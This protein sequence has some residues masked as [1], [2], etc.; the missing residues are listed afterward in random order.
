MADF[1]DCVRA[2]VG[3]RG[4]DVTPATSVDDRGNGKER[5]RGS[6]QP[7]AGR[8]PVDGLKHSVAKSNAP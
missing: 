7:I 6:N 4:I 2:C 1:T 5:E 3:E 8:D